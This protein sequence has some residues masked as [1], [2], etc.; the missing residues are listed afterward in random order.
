MLV[1]LLSYLLS[2]VL[3]CTRVPQGKA[4][5]LDGV[6]LACCPRLLLQ[7]A[8]QCCALDPEVSHCMLGHFMANKV[9]H[10]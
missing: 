4:S 9:P 10:V 7:L 3:T 2:Y 6:T 5:P 1:Y 8:T